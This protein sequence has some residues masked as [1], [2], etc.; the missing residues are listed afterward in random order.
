MSNYDGDRDQSFMRWITPK[1]VIALFYLSLLATFLYLPRIFNY[2][3]D[4]QEVTLNIYSFVE[5]ISPDAL[6]K[7]HDETGINASITY[8]DS[9]EELYT[10]LRITGGEGY[11]LLV[12][13]D[14]MV[15][16]LHNEGLL[17]QI[18]HSKLVNFKNLD[19][20]LKGRFFDPKNQYSLPYVWMTYGFLF[21]KNLLES[22]QK[23]LSLSF[24]FNSPEQQW[25]IKN[26][27]SKNRKLCMTN[28]AR[29]A[30]C[31][32]AIYLF[33]R[34]T[35]L[36]KDEYLQIKQLLIKQKKWVENYTNEGLQYLL[37]G[38][39]VPA[40]YG[41]SMFIRNAL[42]FFDQFDFII[43]EE[44]SIL[45]IENLVIPRASKK[46]DLVYKL[47]NFLTIPDIALIS[48]N[49]YGYNPTNIKAYEKIDSK[50]YLNKNYFPEGK[51]FDRLHLIHNNLSLE[52][53]EDIWLAVKSA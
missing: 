1:L 40:A 28:D 16:L 19:S 3:N 38:N 33:G 45:S 43:P 46:Q 29:E 4:E 22:N 48:S 25:S 51:Q 9:N 34:V 44:G 21:D 23:P 14:Y 30:V 41:P 2:F 32:A 8:F 39:I 47:I 31:L 52:Q 35:N 12:V 13:S 10:K 11:D 37:I 20:R 36:T 53:I 24:I 18:E 17:H 26:T 42:A 6:S 27:L 7:F 15:E 49:A 50:I 5:L